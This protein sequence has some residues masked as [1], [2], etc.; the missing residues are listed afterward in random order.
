L[1]VLADD[2]H[3]L[4]RLISLSALTRE[5]SRGAHRRR[6]FPALDHA[7]DGLHVTV[8]EETAPALEDWT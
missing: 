5:E 1:A 7:L 6:D 3:P 4:A 2:P 8:A